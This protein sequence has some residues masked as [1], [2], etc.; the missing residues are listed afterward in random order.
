VKRISALV[1]ALLVAA[2]FLVAPAGAAADVAFGADPSQAVS[3]SASCPAASCTFFW[4]NTSAGSDVVPFPAGGG[5]GTITSVT[6]PAME[7]PGEMQAVVLTTSITT[8]AEPGQS[9]FRCCKVKAVSPA[10]KVQAGKV[11]TVPLQLRVSATPAANPS[12][13]C[14]TSFADAVGITV[15]TT[16]ASAPLHPTGA[17]NPAEPGGADEFQFWMPGLTQP[18]DSFDFGSEN[19]GTQLLA[20]YTF[21]VDPPATPGPIPTAPVAP[22]VVAPGPGPAGGLKLNKGAD[23][24]AADGRTV[25][26]GTAINPPAA[27]TTQSLARKGFVLGRGS[28]KV[29]SG[30]STPIKLKLNR[31][32]R[33]LLTERGKLVATLSVVAANGAGE[34]QTK[35]SQVTVKPAKPAKQR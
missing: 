18:S 8:G 29:A 21:A 7:E 26:L 3:S 2:A 34:T 20:R 1:P 24:L 17:T 30:G 28:T 33:A 35:T 14:D 22:P 15:L 11:S 4:R 23:R 16:G 25:N 31:R 6:L 27:T 12:K 13:P 9:T 19:P 32:G 5:S 10:F